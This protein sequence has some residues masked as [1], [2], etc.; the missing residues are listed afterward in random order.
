MQNSQDY[1]LYHTDGCHLCELA[2]E[3]VDNENIQYNHIDIC[4]DDMLAARY[5]VS[6]PVVAQGDRTLFWPF[7]QQQLNNFIRGVS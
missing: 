1:V 5:G 2:K 3:L 6:I 4:D 7:D